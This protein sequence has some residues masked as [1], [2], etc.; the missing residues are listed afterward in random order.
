M[1]PNTVYVGRPTKYGNPFKL[2]G[3][4]IYCDASHR[5]KILSQ[6]VIWDHDNLYNEK[7]GNKKVVELYRQWLLGELP[8]E[9][10]LGNEIV[11]PLSSKKIDLSDLKGKNLACW[12]PLNKPCHTDILIELCEK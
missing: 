8:I 6:W 4:M 7:N 11:V 9:N 12:C 10:Y 5:R 1:P 2:I 3:D